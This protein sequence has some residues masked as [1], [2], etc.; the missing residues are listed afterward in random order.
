MGAARSD[1]DEL[2]A[3][4]AHHAAAGNADDANVE[5][6]DI[7]LV[8]ADARI[9]DGRPSVADHA[10][11]GAGAADL[12]VD[13]VG[14]A[15]IHQRACDACG[16]ARQHRHDG[17]PAH[18]ANVH[19]AAVAAHDHQRR[20]NA[21]LAN[22]RLRHGRGVDHLRQDAGVDDGGAGPGRQAVEL[23]DLVAA[24]RGQ[25]GID[26]EAAHRF[27]GV[28]VINAKGGTRDNDL[29]A[30]RLEFFD[31]LADR[32]VGQRLLHQKPVHRFH[33]A[34]GRKLDRLHR[35][36]ALGQQRFH[37]GRHADDADACDVALEQ[38]VGGL[39]CRMREKDHFPGV[40]ARLREDIAEHLDH[41]LGDATRIGVGGQHG[42]PS[43]HLVGRIVD[44]DGLGEGASDV[45]TNAIGA[46]RR[47]RF[48]HRSRSSSIAASPASGSRS[49]N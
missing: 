34:A 35:A 44:Q 13:A 15:Q 4:R 31:R 2:A 3:A 9:F 17:A 28:V 7:G 33:I 8:A 21:G 32:L 48:S 39:G 36:L 43:D 16:R 25:P 30:F 45:D 37:A 14:Y 12:E 23:G 20:L 11:I 5:R 49:T 6:T 41:A 19:H 1:I 26:H 22:T 27:F 42:E 47:R 24:G 40:D 46:A 10:D 18:L 29:C 38:C